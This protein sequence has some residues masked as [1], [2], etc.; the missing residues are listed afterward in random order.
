MNDRL[1]ARVEA[2]SLLRRA[3]G[4]GGFGMVIRRGD[5]DRGAIILMLASRG[6]HSAFVERTLQPNGDYRW[7][8]VGPNAE[9]S[10]EDRAKWIDRRVKFDTDLWL[11]ELDIA[12]AERFIAETIAIG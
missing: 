9:S 6:Q 3:E 7:Q 8:I 1:P 10:A 11:I 12:E 4:E 5:P 2:S